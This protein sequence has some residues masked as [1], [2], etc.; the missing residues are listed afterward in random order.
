MSLRKL[1]HINSGGGATA[2]QRARQILSAGG[3][4]DDLEQKTRCI[5]GSASH[6]YYEVKALP[7]MLN[8]QSVFGRD[9]IHRLLD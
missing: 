8:G 9:M 2:F 1:R 3:G 5:P 7:V 6:L 4:G